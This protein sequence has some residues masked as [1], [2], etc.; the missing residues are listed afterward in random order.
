M[1]FWV[2]YHCHFI[3]YVY[4]LF[5]IDICAIFPYM[6]QCNANCIFLVLGNILELWFVWL[7]PVVVYNFH[8]PQPFARTQPSYT[9]F[10]TKSVISPFASTISTPLTNFQ[11][12]TYNTL[13]WPIK[14][15]TFSL[16][17]SYINF[18]EGNF[19]NCR[20]QR[21]QNVSTFL[22]IYYLPFLQL[23]SPLG[24][25]QNPNTIHEHSWTMNETSI[26]FMNCQPEVPER[27]SSNCSW[28]TRHSD[29]SWIR[30]A[31]KT[32]WAHEINSCWCSWMFA[33][34]Q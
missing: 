14:P 26:K 23:T 33:C 17:T 31:R 3:V 21:H 20:F 32:N 27:C 2:D 29:G 34:C 9:L 5:S 4:L 1:Y 11:N 12:F 30:W 6:I 24:V 22:L 10:A 25:Y 15:L 19:G 16:L 8:N 28:T 7:H 18:A 13:P